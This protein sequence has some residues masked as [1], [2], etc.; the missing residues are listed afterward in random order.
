[1]SLEL[2]GWG[3][4]FAAAAEGKTG[5]PARVAAVDR[6]ACMLWDAEGEWPAVLRGKLMRQAKGPQDY[7][8][9]GDWVL[10]TDL[11]NEE[12]LVI[13]SILPRR[14]AL[15][16]TAAGDATE[17]QILATNVDTIFVAASLADHL[18][19]RRI[20]RYLTAVW[21][22]GAAPVVVLTKT[23]LCENPEQAREQI[24]EIARNA[25]IMLA[26][27][28]SGSGMREVRK[29]LRPGMTS[30]V[31]GPSG[32]GKSTLINALYGEEIQPVIP[33][34]EADQKGRHTTT[35]R[36]LI[37]LPNKALIIDTPGIREFQL[38]D[39]HAGLLESFADIEE[40]A[41]SCRFTN[42]AHATEP[43]CAVRPRL[44]AGEIL[45]DRFA[46]Y[47]KLKT[48]IEEFAERRSARAQVEEKRRTKVRTR[49]L[50][51][52]LKAKG[53]I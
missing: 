2:L 37:Y 10:V 22:S 19:L 3:D 24:A 34:R 25:P 27:A 5:R 23:D 29:L 12:K 52:R 49:E 11:P 1:M 41:A 21:E 18:N 44:E 53:R 32:V 39:G 20:E 36:E 35:R 16:R 33:V 47:Q 13:E 31:V 48:E 38:W 46:S 28:V 40:L 42:C 6:G 50:Q 9:T 14:T 4:F 8:V 30:V 51:D 7:P 15:C 26:S 17:V 43:G 45:G